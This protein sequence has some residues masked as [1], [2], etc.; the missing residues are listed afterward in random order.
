MHTLTANKMKAHDAE[1]RPRG[2]RAARREARGGG[3]FTLIELLVVI[4]IIA[5][6]IGLLVPAVQKVR[7][8][9]ARIQCQNNLKQ[10]S[11]AAIQF[12]DQT[13]EFPGSLRDLEALIG[14]ELASG[15]DGSY[16]YT[17]LLRRPRG[18][19]DGVVWKIEA[20]P[21]YPGITGS[22]TI[23][24]EQSR[25]ADGQFVLEQKTYPTPGADAARQEMVDGIFLEGARTGAELLSLDPAT[26][27]QARDFVQSQATLEQVL[28]IVDK[29]GDA[30][31]SLLELFDWP[32]EYAQ[33][34]DGIDP[35]IEE[36]VRRFLANVRQKMKIDTMS[37][38]TRNQ[39]SVGTG[40]LRSLDGGKTFFSLSELCSLIEHYVSDERVAKEL[41]KK[42]RQAEAANNRGDARNRNRHLKDYFD[43]LERQV[44]MTLTRKNATTLIWLTVGF[45]EVDDPAVP[46]Q[47]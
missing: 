46:P 19:A 4:A 17:Y 38:P 24:A 32:G 3:G 25:L 23:V 47:G 11:L 26:I 34:F 43:E 16:T 15:R 29:D 36:P 10:I 40:F 27:P 44:H 37:E 42:L 13:G 14:P 20:E 8:A 33:R 41:C 45:F 22:E 6:L 39:A 2:R 5:I 30:N 31:V 18:S 28:D 9:A 1:R 21:D 7:E 12:H 35:K